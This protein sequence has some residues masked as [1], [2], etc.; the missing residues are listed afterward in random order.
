[1]R[2]LLIV[3]T[4][5][6]V[7][8]ALPT[9][10]SAQNLQ[11]R[12][13]SVVREQVIDSTRR[14]RMRRSLPGDHQASASVQTQ[15]SVRNRRRIINVRRKARRVVATQEGRAKKG[16]KSMSHRSAVARAH[17]SNVAKAVE[18]LLMV[19]IGKGGIGQQVREIAREQKQAQEETRQQ[20]ETMEAR[21]GFLKR[22]IGPNFKAINGIKKHLQQNRLRIRRLEQLKNKLSDQA[23]KND[24]DQTIRALDEQGRALR[25][26]VRAEEQTK[27][28]FGWL[29]RLFSK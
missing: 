10:V 20:L 9:A 16:A 28:V 13:P 23:V 25:G 18:R 7:L 11:K 3:S 17:M 24:V 22:L 5:A 29:F 27:S 4:A 6:L 8:L 21:R 2:R 26:Q 15:N 14:Q 12:H 19:K 1:M